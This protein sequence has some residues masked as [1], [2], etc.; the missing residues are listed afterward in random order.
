MASGHREH[1]VTQAADPD[2][3]YT[4]SREALLSDDVTTAYT[5]IV[6]GD[7]PYTI[8]ED[9]HFIIAD[10]SGGAIT[11]NLPPA[12]DVPGREYVIK[13]IDA[14]AN[15]TID[16]DGAETIDG[17]ATVVLTGQYDTVQIRS[18]GTEWWIVGV[19]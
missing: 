19:V 16:G 13:K 11:V 6:V 2:R 15:V 14:T 5:S 10:A 1:S 7:S 12:A 3:L 9:D 18:D 4:L 17:A 8:T